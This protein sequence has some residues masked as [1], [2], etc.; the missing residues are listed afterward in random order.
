VLSCLCPSRLLPPPP[1]PGDDFTFDGYPFGFGGILPVNSGIDGISP[2]LYSVL[3]RDFLNDASIGRLAGLVPEDPLGAL[4]GVSGS[5]PDGPP[6][7]LADCRLVHGAAG[8]HG[9]DPWA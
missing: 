8:G 4:T 5:P 6:A 1:P 7:W 2:L 9:R 3:F